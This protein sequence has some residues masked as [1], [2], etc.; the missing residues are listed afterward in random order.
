MHFLQ[1]LCK[2]DMLQ[3]AKASRETATAAGHSVDN[4][5]CT[6]TYDDGYYWDEYVP[7]PNYP[8]MSDPEEEVAVE[9]EDDVEQDEDA[10]DNEEQDGTG[11]GEF[12][13][14]NVEGGSSANFPLRVFESHSELERVTVE[15]LPMCGAGASSDFPLSVQ[16]SCKARMK[17][18]EAIQGEIWKVSVEINGKWVRVYVY[19]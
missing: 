13:C 16:G 3:L 14:A 8:V 19:I 1:N 10:S 18:T 17:E 12:S 5:L 15:D 2:I 4:I 11:V 6:C 7:D 9:D